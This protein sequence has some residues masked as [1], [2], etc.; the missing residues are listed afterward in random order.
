MPCSDVCHAVALSQHFHW[1]DNYLARC[2]WFQ[3][4]CQFHTVAVL[5]AIPFHNHAKY[6]YSITSYG[7]KHTLYLS[8]RAGDD[9][10]KEDYSSIAMYFENQK[11]YFLAGKFY[12]KSTQHAKVSETIY[13]CCT[14]KGDVCGSTLLSHRCSVLSCD[15]QLSRF[16]RSTIHEFL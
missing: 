11:Q 3:R 2:E 7:R 14:E 12:L 6:I 5:C 13:L 9:A 8:F 16:N 4:C 15:A 10:T 1:I